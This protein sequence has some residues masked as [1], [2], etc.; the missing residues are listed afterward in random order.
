MIDTNE[1]NGIYTIRIAHGKANALDVE[2]LEGLREEL[3]RAADA[4]AIVVTGSGSIFS[5]GV[6]L[7]RLVN[8]GADYVRRFYPSLCSFLREL[9]ELPIP[10]VAAANG[11]AIAGGALI[12]MAAD[13]RL[14]AEGKG[15]IG[16]PE[17]LVGVPFPAAAIEVARFAV[18]NDL[19]QS[20]IYTGK[21]LLPDEAAARGLVD[22]AVPQELL[23]ERAHAVAEQMARIPAEIFRAT[24]HALR[25]PVIERI[26]RES[27]LSDAERL[28]TWTAPATH[29]RIRTYLESIARK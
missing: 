11:H 25:A 4:R 26:E 19:L 5:A 16:I 24:K 22:E 3:K 28:A 13:Y 17:L 29:E 23:D 14:M 18:S 20:I 12:V 6:D 1:T 21:T 27:A 9:F 2:L 8:E 10:V 7:F 15:R